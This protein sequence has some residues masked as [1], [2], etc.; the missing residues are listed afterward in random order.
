MLLLV[1]T[2]LL[3]AGWGVFQ[4]LKPDVAWR[5]HAYWLRQEGINSERTPEW[6]R[7]RVV[8]A[9]CLV[10]FGLGIAWHGGS[11]P[12]T[13][14][15]SRPSAATF[16]GGTLARVDM[17]AATVGRYSAEAVRWDPAHPDDTSLWEVTVRDAPA[18]SL[19][20]WIG[21]E[22]APA[23]SRVQLPGEGDIYRGSFQ[24]PSARP[25]GSRLWIE[26]EDQDGTLS[27][28][29]FALSTPSAERR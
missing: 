21:S 1:V 24:L 29:S 16:E 12:D 18:K 15:E 9:V 17:G 5:L 6:D 4:L 14:D 27:R 26:V 28:G 3:L 25:A 11:R 13:E 7:R 22:D 19:T 23:T 8:V 20:A 2:G 10:L